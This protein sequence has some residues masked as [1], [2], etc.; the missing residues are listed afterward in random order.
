ML[1]G[2]VSSTKVTAPI[3]D[4]GEDGKGLM[5]EFTKGFVAGTFTLSVKAKS[6]APVLALR[7]KKAAR[8]QTV[9]TEDVMLLIWNDSKEKLLTHPLGMKTTVGQQIGLVGEIFDNDATPFTEHL[10]TPTKPP[11]LKDVV[12]T[13]ILEVVSPSGAKQQVPMHDDGLNGD[14]V[15]GDGEFTG[16]VTGS[17]VG[18]YRLKAHFHGKTPTG[19]PFERTQESM[20]MVVEQPVDMFDHA[21]AIADKKTQRLHMYLPLKPRAGA[22]L[23]PKFRFYA[24]V[25]GEGSAG[26][27]TPV[28]FA[29]NLGLIK[30]IEVSLGAVR[31][32][33]LEVD[34]HWLARA[35]VKR[36]LVLKNVFIEDINLLVPVD[37]KDEVAVI[38]M[39]S[40]SDIAAP[41]TAPLTSAPDAAAM[42]EA[43]VSAILASGY[44]GEV[45]AVMKQGIPPARNVR[46]NA[47]A[48][49]AGPS[50]VLV[51]GF[52]ADRNPFEVQAEDWTDATF[53]SAAREGN[54]LGVEN[55][56]FASNV[57]CYIDSL[58]NGAGLGSFGMV[59]QSQGGMAVLHILNYYWSGLDYA[60]NGRQIQSVAT[61]YLGNSALSSLGGI[62]G[63]IAADCNP[64][65]SLE[66]KGAQT[67]LSGIT[68]EN[69]DKTNVY[70][71]KYDKGGLF[72]GGYCNALMN[73]LL[74]TPNDGTCEVSY[75]TPND[76][77]NIQDVT[78]GQCH[79]DGMEWPA[80][81]WDKTRNAEMNSKAAR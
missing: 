48:S 12:S 23:S 76:S 5:W 19:M 70:R 60:E 17:E 33:E 77:G 32:L 50:L 13:A 42:V 61:P 14:A 40:A 65:N 25:W 44:T 62:A 2:A 47:T 39:M 31:F 7:A 75:S 38:H 74:N 22:S 27:L 43:S 67:W 41:G 52:C 66:R 3:T 37:M 15:E 21:F 36:G 51:H 30:T 63:I 68:Q 28:A 11:A 10:R 58:N 34:M 20:V 54:P 46:S 9:G 6:M 64:P 29:E 69:I 8:N 1:I 53:Y 79:T 56:D 35:G 73:V 80:S 81:F 71:T 24:E 59:G 49:G 4:S 45:T 55:D 16:S 57:L 26:A 78:V 72:G 18:R